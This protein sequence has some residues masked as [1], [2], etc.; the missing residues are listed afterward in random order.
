[1]RKPFWA[2][3]ALTPLL[4]L[5]PVLRP[6]AAFDPRVLPAAAVDPGQTSSNVLPGDYVGPGACARCHA[7]KFEQWSGHGHARMNQLP[8]PDTVLGDFSGSVLRLGDAAVTFAREGGAYEMK[9]ERGGNTLR[10]Y[11]VTRTVGTR[12]MQFY[13]GVLR[14]GP[15]PAG[16]PLYREHM[17]PFA[18]WVGLGRWLPKQYFDPDGPEQLKDGV[19]LIEGIDHVRDVR[20][21]AEVC[22]NCHNT[23]PYAY[24]IYHP[25][26]VGFPGATVA[27]AAGPLGEA[28]RPADPPPQTAAAFAALNGRLDPDRDMVT[29]GVSCESCHFG[30]RE[31]AT[32]GAPIHFVPTSPYLKVVANDPSRPV[33]DDRKNPATVNGICAQ[34]HSGNSNRFANCAARTNSREAFDLLGGA[35]AGRI[36]CTTCHDPHTTSPPPRDG[37]DPRHLAACVNCH[38][39]Y[40]GEQQ[41]VAHSRHSS[42]SGV[43]CLDCHMPR[44]TLGLNSLVRT[45]RIGPPVEQ[46]MVSQA[47]ANAC[48]LCHLDRTLSWTLAELER[49]WGRRLA[50]PEGE[51]AAALDKPAGDY[52]LR[53]KDTALRLVATESFAHSPL[54]RN[55]FP[56]LVRGLN[57]PEPINR[58]YALMAVERL[59]G[60]RLAPSEYDLT[61]PPAVRRRQIDELLAGPSTPAGGGE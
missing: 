45:H 7:R 34:C 15:E 13:V 50:R 60:G 3:A 1:M 52:W 25:M 6:H 35:C 12:F 44:Y 24:R 48:N 32:S 26:F 10:R 9:V 58:V 30:G 56:D 23:F 37:D 59:R 57:D 49:G 53:G 61:A 31:H 40:R 11:E 41:A 22:M 16:H 17:L 29:L 54:G 38:P 46:P 4:P 5:L 36:R 20:P 42:G 14:E 33:T 39:Q 51:A 2:A 18:Y 47:S 55:R 21:H 8:A 28:L 43:T 19:Q 27:A